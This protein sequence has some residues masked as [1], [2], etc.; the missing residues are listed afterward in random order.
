MYNA[1]LHHCKNVDK[2]GSR[3]RNEQGEIGEKTEKETE[4]GRR[5]TRD[6]RAFPSQRAK[7][8]YG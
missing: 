6:F 1:R 8:N 7:K 4:D 5:E 3:P 2:T